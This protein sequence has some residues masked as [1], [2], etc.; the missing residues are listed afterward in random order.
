MPYMSRPQS[1]HS[2]QFKEIGCISKSQRISTLDEC[3]YDT[4][5]LHI[6]LKHEG[7]IRFKCEFMNCSYTSQSA[8]ELRRHSIMHAP[9]D[10]L[11][12]CSLC[13]KEF[14]SASV[15]KA[16]MKIHSGEKPHMC[17][18]CSFSSTHAGSVKTH[19]NVHTGEFVHT[20]EKSIVI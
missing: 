14:G 19:K 8:S 1:E 5:K 16:H 10:N 3:K 11:H 13:E 15:L 12:I 20:K 18:E 2:A 17:T 9:K 7:I 4:L 6:E